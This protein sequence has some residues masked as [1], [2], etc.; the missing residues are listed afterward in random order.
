M[1]ERP[2]RR[3]G[4]RVR[5]PA[6]GPASGPGFARGEAEGAGEYPQPI[7]REAPRA[8]RLAAE[9]GRLEAELDA[10]R[11][12]LAEVEAMA[13]R[14]PL[15]GVL[16]RRGFERELVRTL[17]YLSRY[18]ASARLV[19]VDLDRFKPVNDVHGHAAGDALLAAVAE[20]LTRQVRASD[21]VARLGGDEF[22]VLLWNLADADALAKARSLE[23][24]IAALVVP[25]Q[26]ASLS[27]GASAGVTPL[28][29]GERPADVVARADAAMY[30]R[31]RSR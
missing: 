4:A 11:R 22:A 1:A 23:A 17:A 6:P 21:S 13:E 18:P 20:T 30:A 19:Y 31:K 14:D 7:H 29:A 3:P 5:P 12:R 15:T 28:A 2:A 16:N 8:A 26:G 24:A 10:M 27:V 9:V 25:W